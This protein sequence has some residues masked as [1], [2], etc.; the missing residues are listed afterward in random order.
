MRSDVLL[1][2]Y[3]KVNMQMQ[4]AIMKANGMLVNQQ[5]FCVMENGCLAVIVQ[6]FGETTP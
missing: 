2:L 3:I 1:H 4:L 6:S 5:M